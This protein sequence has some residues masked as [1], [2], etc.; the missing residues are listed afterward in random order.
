MSEDYPI[1]G[2]PA[3]RGNPFQA[4]PLEKGQSKLLVG[5]EEV[6]ANWARYLKARNPRK[7]LL[8]GESGSGKTSL[9]RCVSEEA[10]KHVHLDMLSL[11]HI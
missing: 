9:M 8:I 1:L 6:S 10:G 5:R 7:V 2:I 4:K 3:L 11:I